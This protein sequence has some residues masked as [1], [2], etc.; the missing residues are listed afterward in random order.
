[1]SE[2]RKRVLI[3]DDDEEVAAGLAALLSDD[4][5]VRVAETGRQAVVAFAEFSP[6]V[7]LLDVHL[8]DTTGIDLLHQFKM[9]AEGTAVIMMSG[10][11]TL[12]LVVESMKLGAETF[13]Q[14]PFEFEML[15]A[16]LQQVQRMLT[17]RRELIALRRNE[18][19]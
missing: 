5:E 14:K 8:P 10:I 1:M 13:L 9:Y 16:V 17:T 11:G 6:D 7:V 15:E 19:A 18:A 4:W 12:D 3:V 2:F